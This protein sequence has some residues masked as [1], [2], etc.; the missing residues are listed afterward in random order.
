MS[1]PFIKTRKGHF[2]YDQGVVVVGKGKTK[3]QFEN[4]I[5]ADWKD[6][7]ADLLAQLNAFFKENNI[8]LELI[9]IDEGSDQ[10]LFAIKQ[11]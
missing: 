6:H 10:D 8:Q 1:K 9:Q 3:Q 11:G 7:P 2:N 5:S 4:F